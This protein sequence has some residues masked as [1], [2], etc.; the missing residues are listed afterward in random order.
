VFGAAPLMRGVRPTLKDR[1]EM[2][3]AHAQTWEETEA[4]GSS[5][6]RGGLT[7]DST[8]GREAGFLTFI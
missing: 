7:N 4:K 1:G 2:K 5:K 6:E 8:G 3:T